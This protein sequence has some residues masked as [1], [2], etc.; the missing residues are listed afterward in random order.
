MPSPRRASLRRLCAAFLPAVVVSAVLLTASCSGSDDPDT[1]G[2]ESSESTAPDAPDAAATLVEQGIQQLTNGK[3]VAAKT[4]FE[5]VLALDPENLYAWYNLGLIAQRAGDN[6]EAVER[7][8]HALVIQ[9]DYT[10]ALYNK[11]ILLET[12]GLDQSIQL[13]RQVIGIDDQ[14]AAAYMRLGFALLHLGETEEG[15][16]FLEQGI[17][18]DPAMEDVQAPS[19]E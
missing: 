19:Y 17:A 6:E 10:P 2:S 18:L 14:M 16:G 15:E 1:K 11:A 3:D 12:T 9:P 13:Y 8:D 5:N 4:T 7:Y